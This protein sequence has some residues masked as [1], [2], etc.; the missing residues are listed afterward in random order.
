MSNYQ[1]QTRGSPNTLGSHERL[2]EEPPEMFNNGD[3]F[4]MNSNA[5]HGMPMHQSNNSPSNDYAAR[6]FREN[7]TSNTPLKEHEKEVDYYHNPTELFRW[8]NYRKWG[9]AWARV[10]SNPEECATWVVSRHASDGR[11]LWRNLPLHLVCMHSA[12]PVDVENM[13]NEDSRDVSDSTHPIR[14]ERNLASHQQSAHFQQLEKLT[15]EILFTYP[16]AAM[17]NDDQGMLPL[18]L[19]IN[20][21]NETSCINERV[22]LLLLATNPAGLRSKDNNGNTPMDLLLE[23]RSIVPGAESVIRIINNASSMIQTIVDSVQDEA[24]KEVITLKQRS[25]NERRASQ[26]IIARLEDELADEH[27]RAEKENSSAGEI[28][29]KSTA[30]QKELHVMKT[31]YDS[32]ELDLDQVRKERDELISTNNSLTAQLDKQEEAVAEMKRQVDENSIDQKR[33]ISSLKSEANAAR[34]MVD[35]VENQLRSKFSNEQD[36][37]NAVNNL[38]NKVSELNSNYQKEKKNLLSEVE[39]LKEEKTLAHTMVEDLTKK[40]NSLQVQK[41]DLNKNVEDALF[42]HSALSA[43]YDKLLDSSKRYETRV[44][45][46]SQLERDGIMSS[47]DKQTKMF[48]AVMKEQ[49]KLIEEANKKET[50]LA[51]LINEERKRQHTSVNKIKDDY[52]VIRTHVSSQHMSV[53]KQESSTSHQRNAP[54]PRLSRINEKC[55]D[56]SIHPEA[57]GQQSGREPGNKENQPRFAKPREQVDTSN[58]KNYCAAHEIDHISSSPPH[59]TIQV[60]R[61]SQPPNLLQFLEHKSTQQRNQMNIS[62]ASSASSPMFDIKKSVPKPQSTP[63]NSQFSS[64]MRHTG[65]YS[66]TNKEESPMVPI[67]EKD[68]MSQRSYSLDD[69]SDLD[70]KIS[71][72]TDSIQNDY[73]GMTSAIKKGMIRVN[74]SFK[75]NEMGRANHNSLNRPVNDRAN[76]RTPMHNSENDVD[77]NSIKSI[78]NRYSKQRNKYA[79]TDDSSVDTEDYVFSMTSNGSDI[80][81]LNDHSRRR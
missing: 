8:I 58:Y 69:F 36:L 1:W 31:K 10:Q 56:K 23:K 59:P 46:T 22:V 32:L 63:Y 67:S 43:E 44:L 53:P 73:V 81:P 35:A 27:G 12:I 78:R 47:V 7:P 33:T 76:R 40:N 45:E 11:V 19:S 41:N 9:G 13:M 6:E 24:T 77:P 48:E 25:E 17:A 62:P 71:S 80:V 79:M 50:E 20:S 16:E 34:A 68:D 39:R 30:L 5:Q 64:E 57:K 75:P 4:K 15:E 60:P 65:E 3:A 26:R 70:S 72:C 54:S 18:H 74:T 14:I 28:R 29:A 49:K 38:E 61:E 21:S 55:S 52:Q 2:P 37:N 51:G 66:S 42:S